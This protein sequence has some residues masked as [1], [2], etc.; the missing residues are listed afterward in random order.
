MWEILEHRRVEDQLRSTPTE[1]QK[2]YEVWK[3][4]AV[5]SG[6]EG[7]KRISGFRDEGLKGNW[8]GFRSSRLNNKFRVLY[9]VN[10]DEKTFFVV[11]VTAHDYRKK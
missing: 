6:P 4:I 1:V 5:F 10:E 11:T 3:N 8:K 7:L 9:E 2:R